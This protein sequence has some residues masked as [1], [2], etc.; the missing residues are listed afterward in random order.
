MNGT[1]NKK[2][3]KADKKLRNR[4]LIF[5]LILIILVFIFHIFYNQFLSGIKNLAEE[6]PEMAINK[7][8]ITLKILMVA[9]CIIFAAF[10]IYCFH[11]SLLIYKS[12]Q[13]P[14]P[15]MRV[16]KD[17]VLITGEKAKVRAIIGF[18]ITGVLV[19]FAFIILLYMNNIF[20]FLLK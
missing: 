11:I 6:S 13:F 5:I 16:I 7:I 18:A 10:T 19:I 12:E 1:Q 2:I 9:M 4:T 15:G 14:P 17:T 8:L 20:Q 3:I